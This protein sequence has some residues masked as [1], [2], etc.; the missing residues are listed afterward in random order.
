LGVSAN[1]GGGS[2]SS[3]VSRSVIGKVVNKAVDSATL[4][5][6]GSVNYSRT[7]SRT[8][9][10]AHA[11]GGTTGASSTHT[12]YTIKN[13]LQNIEKQINRMELASALGLWNFSGYVLS[14][15]PY[16]AQNIA[17][18]YI[19][20]TQGENS[21][22]YTPLVNCWGVYS[23]GKTISNLYGYLKNLRHPI[24]SLKSDKE[25]F[26]EGYPHRITPAIS[27]SGDELAYS[28]NLPQ[29]SVGGLSVVNKVPFGRN[30]IRSTTP[31][32]TI[33]IGKIYNFGEETSE[34]VELD[35]DSLTSHVFVTGSTGTGKSNVI[36]EILEGI[37]KADSDIH[38][39][40]VEPAK[41]EYKHAFYGGTTKC[42][43]VL[44]TNPKKNKLLRIN[45]FSFP[46]DVHVLEHIDRLVEIM[47]VCWPMYAA[48]PAILKNAIIKSY[49]E[50]GWDVTNSY[51][52]KKEAIFPNF[53]DVLKNINEIVNSSAFSQDNKGDYIGALFTRVE[54]LTHGLNGLIFSADEIKYEDIFD[55]DTI[56]DLSRVGATETKALIMGLLVMKL[57]EYRS[58][59]DIKPNHPLKHVV[60]LEE[61]HNLL[62]KTS[63]DQSAESSNLMGKSVEMLTNAIAEMRTYGEGFFI[64]DQAPD[65]LDKAV[66]RNTNTKIVLRLPEDQDR[67]VVGHSMALTEEQIPELSKLELGCAAV[68]QNDWEE[69]VLCQFKEYKID[70]NK[71]YAYY[72]NKTIKTQSEIKKDIVRLLIDTEGENT[73]D[74]IDRI[75]EIE[76]ELDAL[77]INI[78]LKKDVKRALHNPSKLDKTTIATLI[79]RLYGYKGGIEKYKTAEDIQSW[80]ESIVTLLDPELRKMGKKYINEVVQ[81]VLIEECRRNVEYKPIAEEWA[82]KIGGKN[83]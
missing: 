18:S 58:S 12:D 50:C 49:E 40:V 29:K 52:P 16:D 2:G 42:Q 44:G 19:A 76:N 43:N 46:E 13:T 72:G 54:S 83:G 5:G 41:G 51:I 8:A 33:S 6:G 45:P 10:M 70:K 28:M 78:S 3:S 27:L 66:V 23:D 48:M 82:R 47:N 73:I 55:K 71:R 39:L 69:A 62:K 59:Q 26:L 36:Y 60:V 63:T 75:S 35:L 15:N 21:F 38:F 14:K 57:Q 79:T 34:S 67:S 1:I 80:N 20:L 53:A 61:A 37:K 9:S 17:Y 32:R 68:Y 31:K 30:V 24:F 64:V 11:A 4:F 77:Q 56:V 74:N 22:F 65:L 25:E 7:W 81:C